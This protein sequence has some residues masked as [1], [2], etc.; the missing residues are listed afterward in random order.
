MKE[1][2]R[3]MEPVSFSVVLPVYNRAATLA[4]ALESVLNQT[5]PAEEILVVDDGSSDDIEAGLAPYADRVTLIRQPNGGVANARNHAARVARGRW[6]SFQDSDDLWA[7][8]HLEVQAR[9]LAG[10]A[11]DV[12]CHLGDVTYI[13]EGYNERLLAIKNRTFPEERAERIERALPLVISGMTLQAAAIR[14]DVFA[15]LGGFD[16][17]MR[18]LSDTAFFCL[19]ALEGPFLVT[20]H[21]MGDILR[22]PGDPNAITSMHRTRRLYAREMAVRILARIPQ[23]R[24]TGEERGMVRR[25]L[26]GARFQMAE[27]LA[28]TDPTAARKLLAASA[29]QHPSPAVGWA[30]AALGLV[31]GKRGFEILRRRHKVLDRS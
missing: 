5:R 30:K 17:D 23:D 18:M 27:V 9:D 15:R 26:S 10:A 3:R 2:R 20:G 12:V 11:P 1:Y 29:M 28:E 8:D 4:P 6:L 19:L 22:E 31:L 24:L 13:G 14:R 7:P 25:M 16:E 21:N